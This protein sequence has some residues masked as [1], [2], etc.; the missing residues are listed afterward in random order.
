MVRTLIGGVVAGIVLFVVGFVFWATPLA[1]IAYKKADVPASAAV[2]TALAQ[3][4]TQSGT[5]TYI[6]P[7]T[8]T[9]EG[10][11]LYGRGP[12]AT[13]H[14]N[15]G[16]F[17]AED[18]SMLLPGFIV[19]VIAGLLIAFGLAAA[20]G[21][22]DFKTLARLVVLVSLGFTTWSFLAAPIFGHHGWTYWIYA[23]VAE[24]AGLILAGLVVARWFMPHQAR[25]D[26]YD[27]PREEEPYA[28]PSA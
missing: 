2:Q 3:N 28:P 23:F 16:G 12:V 27:P 18:M 9:A 14:F 25:S 4:L 15:T 21:R 11:T 8:D 17:P 1:E 10:T 24:S 5:G 7:S 26:A 20:A 22:R 19:A 6:I 13:L